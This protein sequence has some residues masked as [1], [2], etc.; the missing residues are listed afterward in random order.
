MWGVCTLLDFQGKPG[1]KNEEEEE[2]EEGNE[3]VLVRSLSNSLLYSVDTG[4]FH[5]FEF[6]ANRICISVE[7]QSSMTNFYR[8][9]GECLT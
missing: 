9:L 6:C 4:H 3:L 5:L 1:D 2:E 8:Y 7:R